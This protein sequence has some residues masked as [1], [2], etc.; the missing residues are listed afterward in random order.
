M[1]KNEK[2]AEQK[3]EELFALYKKHG[4]EDYGEGVTQ[5][6]HM[7]Q[8]AK[9]AYEEGYDDE[10][11]LASFFHDIGH[12]LEHSEEMGAFGKKDHDKLGHDLLLEYGFSERVAK[13]VASHVATKRYLTYVD[14]EYYDK[15]SDA[16]KETLKYQGGPMSEEEAA[17]YASDPL[18]DSYIKIRYWDDLGKEIDVPVEEEDMKWLKEL[19]LDYLSRKN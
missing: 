15:L 14:S 10:M 9:L 16:S 3:V 8:C 5:L 18:I 7:V 12:L 11:V 17:A 1:N 6:M 4:D 19:T 2:S 13:L